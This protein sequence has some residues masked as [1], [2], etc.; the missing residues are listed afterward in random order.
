VT[1]TGDDIEEQFA[2]AVRLALET[3]EAVAP[4]PAATSEAAPARAHRRRF[5]QWRVALLYAALTAMVAI[6]VV[7]AL[8]E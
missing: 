2:R 7:A 5:G 8:L 3:C 6:I 4:P 1:A